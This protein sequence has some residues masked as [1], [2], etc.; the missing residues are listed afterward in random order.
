MSTPVITYALAFPPLPNN[1]MTPQ[2]LLDWMQ[3]NAVI[4]SEGALPGVIVSVLPTSNV[5]MVIKNGL[6]YVWNDT[7]EVYVALEVGPEIGEVVEL[8]FVAIDITRYC[9][10]DGAAY[11]RIAPYDQ[12]YAKIGVTFGPGDGSTTFNVPDHRARAVESYAPA[13]TPP[14]LLGGLVDVGHAAPDNTKQQMGMV[15]AIRY[16]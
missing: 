11:P 1:E 5:G 3:E 4:T 13:A 7:S 16:Q 15:K 9:F 2:Q 8:A 12:L 14:V 6:L 10:C